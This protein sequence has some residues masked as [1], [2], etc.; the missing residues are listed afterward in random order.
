VRVR[1]TIGVAVAT[2]L[3]A[4][5]LIAVASPAQAAEVTCDSYID[6]YQNRYEVVFTQMVQCNTT[7]QQIVAAIARS[8]P[9]PWVENSRGCTGV[10]RC[11]A[12]VGARNP[13]GSQQFC[14]QTGGSYM[15]RAGNPALESRPLPRRS[16]CITA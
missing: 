10:S 12:T 6:A 8:K 16:R 2:I 15:W 1:R 13:G 7:S 5:G 11:T 9:L 14:A 4:T 3:A